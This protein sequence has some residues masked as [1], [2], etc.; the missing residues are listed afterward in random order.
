MLYPKYPE[1][2]HA[3]TGTTC[4]LRKER[5]E[6]RFEP[7]TKFKKYLNCNQVYED[8][9]STTPKRP[10]SKALHVHAL[11]AN[12]L[13]LIFNYLFNI[14]EIG[15]GRNTNQVEM[16]LLLRLQTGAFWQEQWWGLSLFFCVDSFFRKVTVSIWTLRQKTWQREYED[17]CLQNDAAIK[18]LIRKIIEPGSEF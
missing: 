11:I 8:I 3:C 1:K 18:P 2:P 5:P 13:S 6:P 10:K 7:R 16:E 9:R 4:K 12:N 17:A 14:N 15:A